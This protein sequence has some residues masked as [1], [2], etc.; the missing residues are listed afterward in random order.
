MWAF[1]ETVRIEQNGS[2]WSA[3][4]TLDNDG[5]PES[6]WVNFSSQPDTTAANAAGVALA[7]DMNNLAA[8]AEFEAQIG[9]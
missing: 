6:F 9:S 1:V 3:L 2:R 8:D 7:A 5:I 4:I